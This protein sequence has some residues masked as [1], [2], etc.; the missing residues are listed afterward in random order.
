MSA[1]SQQSR[2]HSD[3]KD[4]KILFPEATVSLTPNDLVVRGT[5]TSGGSAFT[6]TLAPVAEMIGKIVS[7]LMVARNGSK[8]ITIA[9]KVNDGSRADITLNLAA[10]SVVL[11]CDGFKYTILASSGI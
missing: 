9:D 3:Q 8:D 5:T 6:I 2:L 4:Q 10:D 1:E 11:Y 7:I